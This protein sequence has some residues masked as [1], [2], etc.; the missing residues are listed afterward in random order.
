MS[1]H[2]KSKDKTKPIIKLVFGEN[3]IESLNKI[4]EKQNQE[5][6]KIISQEY[7]I[8]LNVLLSFMY[9][10]SIQDIELDKEFKN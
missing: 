1:N 6:M 4:H 8:P 7:A 3:L 2:H 5:L 9:D 10:Q